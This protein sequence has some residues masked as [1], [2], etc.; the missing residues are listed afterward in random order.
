MA[1]VG[2]TISGVPKKKRPYAELGAFV[3]AVR[4]HRQMTASAVADKAGMRKAQVTLLEKGANVEIQFY[5]R[6]AVAMGFRGGALDMF[7]AVDDRATQTLLRL[8]RALPDD[9][10]RKDALNAVKKIVVDGV[11]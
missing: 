8:W 7:T 11:E 1:T 4:E 10:A 3:K 9:V 2:V 6:M 5:D